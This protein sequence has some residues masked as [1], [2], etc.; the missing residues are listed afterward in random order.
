M[1]FPPELVENVVFWL[2]ESVRVLGRVSL[3]SRIW[4]LSCRHR[5][6]HT[7]TVHLNSAFR[8]WDLIHS[9]H[10]TIIDNVRY[11]T[12]SGKNAS[13]SDIRI[14]FDSAIAQ[15]LPIFP[16]VNTVK[17]QWIRPRADVQ[18]MQSWMRSK[19]PGVKALVAHG[20]MWQMRSIEVFART[21]AE[22]ESLCFSEVNFSIPLVG[23]V[24]GAM[25]PSTLKALSITGRTLTVQSAF[26]MLYPVGR[27]IPTD[28][29]PKLESLTVSDLSAPSIRPLKIALEDSGRHL[30]S[31]T[32]RFTVDNVS[33]S[34]AF[35]SEIDLHQYPNLEEF[36]L[37]VGL[38]YA[39]LGGRRAVAFPRILQILNQLSNN[40][41][42]RRISIHA[43]FVDAS[44][45][46]GTEDRLQFWH[47]LDDLFGDDKHLNV[48]SLK[49]LTIEMPIGRIALSY[50]EF[51]VRISNK[52]PRVKERGLLQ[53]AQRCWF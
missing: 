41:S 24:S 18:G 38:A 42:L 48:P 49:S 50:K 20:G 47:A 19:L 43:M 30:R 6:F 11:L 44:D 2:P 22:L 45:L 53:F 17:I 21:F 28:E 32:F 26:G 46:E 25:L 7:V 23:V 39:G 34:D 10:T 36:R 51:V 1:Y 29:V 35:V 12:I 52:M 3:T 31:L 16:N 14:S 9:P 5:L 37:G 8:F 27:T 40:A 4:A 13:D 33:A 15:T